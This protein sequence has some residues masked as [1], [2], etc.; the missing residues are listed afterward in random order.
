ME[1][2]GPPAGNIQS[3]AD[4]NACTRVAVEPNT[5]TAADMTKR[6]FLQNDA[7]TLRFGK[8][9]DFPTLAEFE[10]TEYLRHVDGPS[11]YAPQE[12]AE[13]GVHTTRFKKGFARRHESKIGQDHER[14]AIQ[15]AKVAA[16]DEHIERR[17]ARLAEL[18]DYNGYNVI[19]GEYDPAKE[20][21]KRKEIRYIA[22]TVSNELQRTGHILLRNSHY[23]FFQ[24]HYTGDQHDNRQ[25]QI[26]C[27]GLHQQKTSSVLGIGRADVS[28]FGVEDQFS[29]SVYDGRYQKPPEDGGC[30]GLHETTHPG[31]FTPR[32]QVVGIPPPDHHMQ[33]SMRMQPS[34]L[35]TSSAPLP[36]RTATQRREAASDAQMMADLRQL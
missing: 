12:Y 35:R 29:H 10:R 14:K 9:V 18:N 8:K 1:R 21:G 26:V 7:K 6:W 11:G 3:M 15:A 33:R 16:A 34:S 19:S 27:E 24:P 30:E 22:D 2:H 17:R 28:S 23:R 5:P 4:L 32:K 25:V 13:Q 36:P 31:R 20:R